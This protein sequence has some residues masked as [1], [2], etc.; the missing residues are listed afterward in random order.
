MCAV[1][2]APSLSTI[3][4]EALKKAGHSSPAAALITRGED[5]WMEEVKQDIWDL[6]HRLRS[7][8]TK[9][10]FVTTSNQA[11]ISQESDY[12]SVLNM[13]LL[14]GTH[15]GTAQTGDATSITLAA[16]EDAAQADV[17]GKEILIYAGTS[18][19]EIA[20]C[21]AYSATTKIATCTFTTAPDNT[22]KYLIVETYS[23]LDYMPLFH[24]DTLTAS[25]GTPTHF[26]IKEDDDY[27]EFYLYP[28]PYRASEIPWGILQRYYVNLLVADLA[29]TLM[30]TLYLKWRG[31]WIQ[32]VFYKCL[33]W[34]DDDRT[35]TEKTL[36]YGM[37]KNL[38]LH[39]D[40][41]RQVSE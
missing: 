18:I 17:E 36:Y 11:T 7:L 21:T 38:I 29:G 15:Y 19:N 3:V 10:P 22:S 5:Y 1:P 4:T 6:S 30:S 27:G 37:L 40:P 33:Q 32:G 41:N 20:R 34:M 31:V 25:R 39:E 8:I 13:T 26:I 14:D 35:E 2:T 12:D 23:P 28:T 9:Y 16:A 24:Y